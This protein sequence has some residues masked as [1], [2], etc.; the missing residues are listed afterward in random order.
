MQESVKEK[1]K[2]LEKYKKNA[3]TGKN[4]I[5][6]ASNNNASAA[7]LAEIK[8]EKEKLERNLDRTMKMSCEKESQL[9]DEIIKLKTLNYQL[10]D[11]REKY[12]KEYKDQISSFLQEI[13][14]LKN[15][16]LESGKK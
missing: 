10:I 3:K 5:N 9:S 11:Q 2:K 7:I 1:D 15:K 8:A 12:E 6:T 4:P 13:S 16:A 14:G